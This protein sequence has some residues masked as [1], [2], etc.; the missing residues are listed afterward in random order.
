MTYTALQIKEAKEDVRHTLRQITNRVQV[1]V[2]KTDWR[3][4]HGVGLDDMGCTGENDA[5]P[6][7]TVEALRAR[8]LAVTNE[9]LAP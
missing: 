6:D 2:F 8:V 9:V 1:E 7:I 3:N 5:A 4:W